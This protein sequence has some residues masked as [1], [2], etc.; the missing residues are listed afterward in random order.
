MSY[1]QINPEGLL[2]T[3]ARIAS[4]A[5][6]GAVPA[7]VAV[8]PPAADPVSTA[9]TATFQARLT[10]ITAYSSFAAG[11]T[12]VR[13][14]MVTASATTYLEQERLNQAVLSG[15]GGGGAAA[16]PP[17]VPT[18]Q[19]PTIPDVP[20]PVVPAPPGHG[21]RDCPLDPRRAGP[22]ELAFDGAA[23]A[24]ACR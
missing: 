24:Y 18:L 8:T 2:S 23:D 15:S 4:T 10:G 9:V 20:V 22:R 1:L 13:G 3:G 5:D 19:I 17:S 21:Q 12:S 16:A 7:G 14:Q 11:I 6:Q